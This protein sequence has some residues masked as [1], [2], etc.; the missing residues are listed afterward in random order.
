MTV[1]TAQRDLLDYLIR[2]LLSDGPATEQRWRRGAADAR[3]RAA[4]GTLLLVRD[5]TADIV[6]SP[7]GEVLVI[8]TEFGEPTR[9]AT[10]AE[11]RISLFRGIRHYPEL[12]SFLP[13]RPP[14]AV[15]CESCQGTGVLAA[16]IT[17][18]SL[19][20]VVC[21]CGGAG[22]SVNDVEG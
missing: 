10:A 11:Q 2:E 14:E 18:P 7:A 13:A 16:A 3:Q 12:V 15:S 5:W 9:P 22:W 1:T 4:E 20:E 8:D 6:L 17:N 19:R 21:A